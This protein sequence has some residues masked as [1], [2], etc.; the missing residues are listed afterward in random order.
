MTVN[1]LEI[2]NYLLKPNILEHFIDYFEEHF[3]ASQEAEH[4]MTLLG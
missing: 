2:R 4:M 1:V 3:I